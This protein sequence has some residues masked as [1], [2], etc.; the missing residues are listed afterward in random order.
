[1]VNILIVDDNIQIVDVLK[2]YCEKENYNV[3]VAYDGESALDVFEDNNI[4][5]ILLDV[6]LPKLDGF[7]VCKM[8]RDISTVPIIMITA[9]NDDFEKIMGLDIGADDYITKPFSNAEVMARMRAM[10]RRVNVKNNSIVTL[11]NL[12]INS[13]TY[14]VYCNEINITLTKKEFEILW[15]LGNNVGKVFTREDLLDKIWG[16]DYFGDNRTV[17]SHIKRLRTKL[18]RIDG[19]L[20]EITTVWGVGYKFEK[21]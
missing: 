4:D 13:E 10:L 18:S 9:R 19:L 14:E 12:L 6:M 1:M 20:W 7:S 2:K 3:Y 11:D 16:Y 17:D 21:K 8:I 5:L 15:L